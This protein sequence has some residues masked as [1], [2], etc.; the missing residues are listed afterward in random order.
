MRRRQRN[1]SRKVDAIGASPIDLSRK[2]RKRILNAGQASP[3]IF[4]TVQDGV[5]VFI[6][7]S[8]LTEA[9]EFLIRSSGIEKG[10]L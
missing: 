9:G 7:F 6:R 1:V 3:V 4:A 5:P 2:P 10:L 8:S